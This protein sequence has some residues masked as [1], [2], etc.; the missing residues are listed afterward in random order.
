MPY[1]YWLVAAAVP[2][3]WIVATMLPIGAVAKR[4]KKYGIK[5][6]DLYATVLEVEGKTYSSTKDGKVESAID[7]NNAQVDDRR[8][9]CMT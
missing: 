2:L 7:F 5:Y 4:R 3:S 6:P 8:M 9:F 1:G